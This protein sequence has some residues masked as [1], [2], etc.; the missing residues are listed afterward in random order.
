MNTII[1]ERRQHPRD[2]VSPR[3]AINLLQPHASATI[4]SI[5][6][7]EGGLC[8]RLREALEVRSLVR[9]QVTPTRPGDGE[10]RTG[11]I[12][13]PSRGSRPVE[14][15]G[16]VAWV[17]Q[18]LDLRSV[19]PFLFDIGIEF[20]DPPPI[21]R[22]LIA[23]RGGLAALKDRAAPGK[24]LDSSVIRGRHFIPRLEREASRPPRW[25]LVVS[26]D[27]APC[28]S[29]RYP[30]ERTALIAW[31]AFKRQRGRR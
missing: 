6:Y 8:L 14:C 26:V 4:S 10:G 13:A 22:Q 15:T 21:L 3:V 20:V 2:A 24:G 27:G 18:R 28:F 23:Q 7:S 29:G 1:A 16:R 19:P 25:H 5:N 11:E 12:S 17:I 9:L 31:A 30:S